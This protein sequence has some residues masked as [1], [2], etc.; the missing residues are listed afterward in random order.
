LFTLFGLETASRSVGLRFFSIEQ[1][2]ALKEVS[3]LRSLKLL[4]E[5]G[6]YQLMRGKK[7]VW[8]KTAGMFSIFRKWSPVRYSPVYWKIEGDDQDQLALRCSIFHM[9][10]SNDEHDPRVAICAKGHAG[11]AYF[12]RY[13]WDNELIV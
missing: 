9:I 1:H 12:G 4:L 5:A 2:E 6:E 10:R 7:N 3:R 11:E 8:R 13:F